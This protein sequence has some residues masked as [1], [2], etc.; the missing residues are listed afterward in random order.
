M[1]FFIS[2]LLIIGTFNFYG[3]KVNAADASR[4]HFYVE[5]DTQKNDMILLKDGD[6]IECTIGRASDKFLFYT[7]AGSEEMKWIEKALI[8]SAIYKNGSTV[9]LEAT[10]ESVAKEIDWRMVKVT[11]NPDDV[12]HLVK[13]SD[14]SV[15][16]IANFKER[17]YKNNTLETAAEIMAKREAAAKGATVVLVLK[18]EHHKSYGDPP[19]VSLEAESY[20]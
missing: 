1:R 17:M 16:Y 5:Q 14:I 9:D 3:I 20:K 19:A 2:L 11:R 12:A 7:Q 6:V 8:S 18:I 4:G 13:V 15:K 10:T